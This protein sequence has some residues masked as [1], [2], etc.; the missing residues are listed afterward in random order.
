MKRLKKIIISILVLFF[1]SCSEETIT[2][3][4]TNTKELPCKIIF[5]PTL[6]EAQG[7][8][9][10]AMQE[11]QFVYSKLV[12]YLVKNQTIKETIFSIP[13]EQGRIDEIAI[14][15]TQLAFSVL[16]KEGEGVL[17]KIYLYSIEE[18]SHAKEI[19]VY[20]RTY[21]TIFPLQLTLGERELYWIYQNSQE[22]RSSIFSYNFETKQIQQI[23]SAPF[24]TEGFGPSILF[25]SI[26]DDILFH[27]QMNDD[28]YRIGGYD[29]LAQTYQWWFLLPKEHKIN[30]KGHYNNEQNTIVLYGEGAEG[31]ILYQV[32]ILTGFIRKFI[33]F[34]NNARIYRDNIQISKYG[35]YYTVQTQSLKIAPQFFCI[36]YYDFKQKKV[37]K[38]NGFDV[39]VG[40]DYLATLSFISNTLEG[41]VTFKLGKIKKATA[42]FN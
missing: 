26:G 40:K 23:V 35:L 38:K 33:N 5:E 21:E 27:D 15:S 29:I 32:D 39:S 14:T 11:Q 4:F 6:Y 31:D 12:S 28:R 17:Q 1:I 42:Q 10:F 30:F 2:I 36:E 3:N 13:F 20:H 22:S 34:T 25:L 8:L 19:V 7:I 37:F 41:G 16:E 24:T 18:N 9:F